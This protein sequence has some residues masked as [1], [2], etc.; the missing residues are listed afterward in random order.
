M[1]AAR[2]G[3]IFG[4]SNTNTYGI[5]NTNMNMMMMGNQYFN[6]QNMNLG[7]GNRNE[8]NMKNNI[9]PFFKDNNNI[10]DDNNDD[11]DDDDDIL[12]RNKSI[13][14]DVK[15]RGD[16][17]NII[18]ELSTGSKVIIDGNKKSTFKEIAKKFCQKIGLDDLYLE[19]RIKF[20]FNTNLIRFDS[21]SSLDNLDIKNGSI[22]NVYDDDGAQGA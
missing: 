21:S 2:N 18:F 11:D 12:P 9:N 22:I 1:N 8:M 19:K 6:G 20:I 13:C 17:I 16:I 7:F 4:F 3:N 14:T 10:E 5:N 15:P